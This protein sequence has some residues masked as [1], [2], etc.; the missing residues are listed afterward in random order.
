MDTGIRT[1][2]HDRTHGLGEQGRK[3]AR[4]HKPGV[5]D[6]GWCYGARLLFPLFRGRSDHRFSSVSRLE[7][8]FCKKDGAGKDLILFIVYDRA[9]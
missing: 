1:G 3:E 7:Q 6:L 2:F 9:F 4:F 5:L 8:S